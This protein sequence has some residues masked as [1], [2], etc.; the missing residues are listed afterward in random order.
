MPKLIPSQS[1]FTSKMAFSLIHGDQMTSCDLAWERPQ[2][3]LFLYHRLYQPDGRMLWPS[4]TSLR[5]LLSPTFLGE[6][7]LKT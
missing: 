6:M 5:V 7:D 2:W 1:H 4:P 3:L